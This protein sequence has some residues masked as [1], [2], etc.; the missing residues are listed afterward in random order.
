MEKDSKEMEILYEDI[1]LF[2]KGMHYKCYKFMGAHFKKENGINGYRFTVWAPNA[3]EVRVVGDFNRWNGDKHGMVKISKGGLWSI[4]IPDI[5]HNEIYKFEILGKNNTIYLKADPYG[6][7]S[8]KRPNTASITVKPHEYIWNDEKWIT[9]RKEIDADACPINIYEVHMGSWKRD[10][11]GEFLSYKELARLLPKYV[12]KM[13]Y[14]HV[15][16]MPL[17]EHPLDD[18]W[19]YQVTGY[20]SPTSRFGKPSDF[21]YFIDCCHRMGIGVILD[22]VPGHFCKDA[23]GLYKFDGTSL[24]EYKDVIKAENL[25]WGAAN[26]DLGKAEVKSFLISNALYWIKEFHVDGLRVDAVANM[27]YLDYGKECG[28][29]HPNSNG[30]NENLEA[31][32]FTKELNERISKEEPKALIIAEESTSWPMV[33]GKVENGSLGYKLKWNMGWMNDILKYMEL[34]S[35]MKKYNHNLITFSLMYAYS[36]NFVLPISHDEVVHGKKSLIDKMWGDYWNKFAGFRAFLAYMYCHPGKKTLFMGSEFAQFIEWRFYEELQ[37]KLLSFEMHAKTIKFTK[38]LNS[39]YKKEKALWELDKDSEGFQ[40]IDVN[41]KEQSII[42]FMRKSYDIRYDLIVVCNFTPKVYYDYKIGVP[43]R[44][45]YVELLNTDHEEF[46]GS[47]QVMGELLFSRDEKWHNC[48]YSIKV[49]IP[50]MATMILKIE[51]IDIN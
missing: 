21:K 44:G 46:G 36:E 38:K 51:N 24:Y 37:W 18:S 26:F 23:H 10:K 31:I 6:F 33:T 48:N 19:G 29:W 20:Y 30:G 35:S 50:P 16:I 43:Y 32:Q 13:G 45:T 49:K 2:H 8:E 17:M 47:G 34:D 11:H 4:F 40:W 12:K 25:G 22:W 5:K 42:I 27:I 14:T 39:I 41:N 15:E 9:I 28:Q 7:F 3:K 1:V